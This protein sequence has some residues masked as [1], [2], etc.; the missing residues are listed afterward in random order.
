MDAASLYRLVR[1]LSPFSCKPPVLYI[2]RNGLGGL[3]VQADSPALRP[4]QR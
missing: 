1:R 4:H 2:F 3:E